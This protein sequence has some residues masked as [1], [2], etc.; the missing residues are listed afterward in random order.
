MI[1]DILIRLADVFSITPKTNLW[2][3]GLIEYYL[4]QH[5]DLLF[6]PCKPEDNFWYKAARILAFPCRHYLLGIILDI[7]NRFGRFCSQGLQMLTVNKPAY[8][9]KSFICIRIDECIVLMGWW[10]LNVACWIWEVCCSGESKMTNPHEFFPL[11]WNRF[12][13]SLSDCKKTT[14]QLLQ[15]LLHVLIIMIY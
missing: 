3:P 15:L 7:I 11:S 13:P 2:E 6:F 10:R 8:N 12:G 4:L 5:I 14:D 1:D 9:K